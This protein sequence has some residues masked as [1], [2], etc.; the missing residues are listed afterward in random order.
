[1]D[2]V[3]EKLWFRKTRW[4][5]TSLQLSPEVASWLRYRSQPPRTQ[6]IVYV[7]L[8]DL[9]DRINNGHMRGI[10]EK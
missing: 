2:R 5:R 3:E 4:P 1:M 7:F 10:V 6:D 8:Y 9:R